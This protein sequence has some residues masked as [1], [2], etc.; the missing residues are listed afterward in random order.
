MNEIILEALRASLE[1][2]KAERRRAVGWFGSDAILFC[3]EE[4]IRLA[5]ATQEAI[6]KEAK[7]FGGV[8]E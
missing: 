1:R 3:K 8:V 6:F 5:I 7:E 2:I 4:D